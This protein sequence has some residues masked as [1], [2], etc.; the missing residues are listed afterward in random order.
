M[1]W[2]RRWARVWDE[3]RYC[4]DACRAGVTEGD[5]SLEALLLALLARRGGNASLCPSEVA[6]TLGEDGWR[7]RMEPVRRAARR[8][9]VEG[10]VEITQGGRVVDPSQVRGAIRIRRGPRW[11]PPGTSLPPEPERIPRGSSAGGE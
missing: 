10:R 5:R 1:E 11:V 7:E 2:R 4:S 8:L 6:R 3:V 9:V